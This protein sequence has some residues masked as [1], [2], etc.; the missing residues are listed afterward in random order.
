MYVVTVLFEVEPNSA[1]SFLIRVRQQ[2]DDSMTHEAGCH[3]FDVCTDPGRPER[4]FLY[5]IYGDRA[6]YDDHLASDH[7]KAFDAEVTPVTRAKHVENW[8]LD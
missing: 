2:A 5:E 4:V 6:A 8:M 1:E 3:R 7:F